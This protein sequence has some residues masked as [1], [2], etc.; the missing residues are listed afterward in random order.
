MIKRLNSKNITKKIVLKKAKLKKIGHYDCYPAH[1]SYLQTTNQ[2]IPIPLLL[3]EPN[4]M[5]FIF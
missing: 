4:L 5:V 1:S 3:H 2:I